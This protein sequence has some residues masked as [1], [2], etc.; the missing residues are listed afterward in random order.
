MLQLESFHEFLN[1]RKKRDVKLIFIGGVKTN[2]HKE[3]LQ[4]VKEKIK[5]LNVSICG[6]SHQ[7]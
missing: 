1:L 5:E 4:K 3:I 2:Q 6:N 7:D